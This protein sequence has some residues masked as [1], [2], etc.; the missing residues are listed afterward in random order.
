LLLIS[1]SNPP[2]L[3]D[4]R[5]KNETVLVLHQKH[6]WLGKVIVYCNESHVRVAS[7]ESEAALIANAPGWRVR[8]AA[9]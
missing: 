6:R 5:Q 8:K 1:A 4:A 7:T 3:A 2:A 9:A